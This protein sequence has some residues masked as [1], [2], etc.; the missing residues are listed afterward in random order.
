M[1]YIF[2]FDPLKLFVL[3]L[4]LQTL[5]PSNGI[6]TAMFPQRNGSLSSFS[7]NFP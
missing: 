3:G 6:A 7:P 2:H 5:V 4:F 1:W